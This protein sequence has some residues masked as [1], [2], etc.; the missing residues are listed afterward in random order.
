VKITE[1]D[2][3]SSVGKFTGTG[4]AKVGDTVKNQ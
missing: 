4:S 1:V 2:A 3:Q